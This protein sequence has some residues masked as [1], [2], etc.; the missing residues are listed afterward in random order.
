ME[1]SIYTGLSLQQ[2]LQVK[3]DL[4]ANNMANLTTP[5]YKS[6]NMVFTEF[7]AK[8]DNGER[9][10]DNLSMVLDYGHYQNSQAGPMQSTGNPLDVALQGPGWFGVQTPEGT[11]YSRAGNFQINTNGELVTGSGQ[12]VAAEGGGSIII[13]PDAKEIKI[14]KDGTVATDQGPV[15]RIGV[16]E[17]I[18]DQSL[19]ATGNGL[20]KAGSQQ[21]P[22]TPAQNTDILQG[23]LEGSNVQPVLEMT[24]MLDTLRSYQNTQR[25]LQNEHDRERTM[26]QRMTR[27][28]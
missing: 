13:P 28:G 24:R 1:N 17:F 26:I 23:M 5:G 21:D 4:I 18:N 15:G 9:P 10:K 8:T 25:M 22:G 7:V 20:Y 2:A 11:M 6:Q 12:L 19:Q 16:F 14:S 27:A 3:M